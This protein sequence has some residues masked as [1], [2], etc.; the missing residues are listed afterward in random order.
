MD[1]KNIKKIKV[2]KGKAAVFW[3]TGAGIVFKFENGV[4]ICVDPYL[5]DSVERLH[6]F[7]RLSLAPLRPKEL[8]FDYLLISHDH[9]DHM[10]V[11]S[12]ETLLRVNKNAKILAPNCCKPYLTTIGKKFTLIHHGLKSIIPDGFI[13]V[14][15]ADHGRLCPDAAGFVISCCQKTIYLT[16]DTCQN[17]KIFKKVSLLKPDIVI[18][19]INGAFGNLNEK[20]AALLVKL[21][22]AKTAIPAHFGLFAEHGG[23]PGL[24]NKY[25]R[26]YSPQTQ[27]VLLKPGR[28]EF[29]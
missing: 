7:K 20:E 24:F 27:V 21:C 13:S 12:M 22:K 2:P 3:L 15:K 23:D 28:G 10:D 26:S 6:G 25:L 17:N 5:S 11:D 14:T 4:I 18:P 16:G 8:K 9:D 1:V 19:C 29:V